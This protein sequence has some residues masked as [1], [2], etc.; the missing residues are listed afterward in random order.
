MIFDYV[1][2]RGHAYYVK[3]YAV[4]VALVAPLEADRQIFGDSD[5]VE[6]AFQA[7]LGDETGVKTVTSNPHVL[8]A[9]LPN[10]ERLRGQGS[11]RWFAPSGCPAGD[12]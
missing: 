10:I 2:S 8:L 7:R 4:P 9:C 1:D 3:G 6:A 12:R 5:Q 11:T